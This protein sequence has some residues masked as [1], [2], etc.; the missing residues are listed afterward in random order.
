M[1]DGSREWSK[2]KSNHSGVFDPR[3]QMISK[4]LYYIYE[5]LLNSFCVHLCAYINR[6]TLNLIE[7]KL[8]DFTMCW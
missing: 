6:E 2:I 8:R 5:F 7:R 3:S 1:L 4:I